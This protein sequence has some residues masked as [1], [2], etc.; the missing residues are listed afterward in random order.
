MSEIREQLRT[1]LM[2]EHLRSLRLR[3]D[4]IEAEAAKRDTDNRTPWE[5]FKQKH[6]P[7]AFNRL[8]FGALNVLLVRKG[9]VT[10]DEIESE[11]ITQINHWKE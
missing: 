9:V 4:R 7:V 1:E 10:Q 3:N 11:A 5:A 2:R 8:C 6:G